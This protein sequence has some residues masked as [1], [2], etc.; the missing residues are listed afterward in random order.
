M[1]WNPSGWIKFHKPGIQ[2]LTGWWHHLDEVS[3]GMRDIAY[4]PH[5]KAYAEP[6]Y[7]GFLR[8]WVLCSDW[9]GYYEIP[10]RLPT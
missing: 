1:P 9:S 8:H 7:N 3:P 10:D 6:D 5:Y 4:V 2:G